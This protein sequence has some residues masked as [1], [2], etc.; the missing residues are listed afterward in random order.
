MQWLFPISFRLNTFHTPQGG[1][2]SVIFTHKLFY[3]TGRINQ[4]L[5]PRIKGVASGADFYF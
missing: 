4:F 2:F 1:L 5:F 3:P